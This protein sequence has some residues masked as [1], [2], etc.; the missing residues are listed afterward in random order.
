MIDK[1]IEIFPYFASANNFEEANSFP[2]YFQKGDVVAKALIYQNKE[3]EL[4]AGSQLRICNNR[5]IA[6]EE[7]LN[8]LIEEKIVVEENGVYILNQSLMFNSISTVSNFVYG[9][10]NNGWI[11]WKDDEGNVLDQTIR[12]LLNEK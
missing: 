12:V 9:G 1:F 10:S 2:I 4:L 5:D 6:S 8:E 3:V 11:Q 7:K